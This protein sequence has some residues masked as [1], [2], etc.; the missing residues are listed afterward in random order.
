[1]KCII[2]SG[3][4]NEVSPRIDL[5]HMCPSSNDDE[6]VKLVHITS[7]PAKSIVQLVKPRCRRLKARHTIEQR[8]AAWVRRAKVRRYMRRINQTR[9]AI[10][11]GRDCS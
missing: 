7:Q 9:R 11:W 4:C 2:K 8:M 1:V 6:V 5:S 10:C 3:Q